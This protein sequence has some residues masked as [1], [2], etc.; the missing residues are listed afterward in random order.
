V[1]TGKVCEQ[2][3][4]IASIVTVSFDRAP[5]APQAAYSSIRAACLSNIATTRFQVSPPPAPYPSAKHASA[6]A[7]VMYR[8]DRLFGT[9]MA[10]MPALF[11]ACG[12]ADGCHAPW[13]SAAGGRADST[14]TDGQCAEWHD[15]LY[16]LQPHTNP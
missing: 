10:A 4:A 9:A 15:Q 6:L 11:A 16:E 13:Q 5:F 7:G 8:V 1:P 12:S 14:T 3:G 2:L